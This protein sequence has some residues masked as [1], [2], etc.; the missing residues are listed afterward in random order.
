[1]D[2]LWETC[3]ESLILR[4]V[5]PR[6]TLASE[7][8]R[9]ETVEGNGDKKMNLVRNELLR[10]F[11]RAMGGGKAALPLEPD[12]PLYV[13]RFGADPAKDPILA[14]SERIDWA[15]S[16]SV[17]VLTG[18][19]GNGKSTELRR[20]K[21][22]LEDR[23]CTVILIDMLEYVIVT[24][25][26]ELSDFILSLVTGFAEVTKQEEGLDELHETYWA[27][28]KNF[29]I[30]T[31]VDAKDSIIKFGNDLTS[32]EL[33]LRLKTDPTFKQTLQKRLRGHLTNL[34][35]EARDYAVA[36][37]DAL[38][39]KEQFP[40]L[41]VVLLVDS[42]EQIRGVGEDAEKVHRSVVETFSGQ[43][44]LDFPQL[45]VVYTAPPYLMSLAPTVA[46]SLGGNPISIWPNIQIRKKDGKEDL[47]NIA[48]MRTIVE[49]RFRRWREF[50]EENHL[51]H[52]AINSGGDIRDFF[53]LIRECLIALGTTR[54]EKTTDDILKQVAQQLKNDM[55]PIADA[56]ARCLFRIHNTKETRLEDTNELPRLARFFDHNLI[57]NYQNGGEPWYDVHPVVVDEI[58]LHGSPIPLKRP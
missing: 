9:R 37:V 53:R 52:M 13:P 20:L 41:K 27:R 11:Y 7:K 15:E 58:K 16:E 21:K 45:H 1:L 29:L 38:R 19:R 36:V 35:R 8:L 6:R 50:I 5:E 22:L 48:I 57:M 56:D 42:L 47:S 18:F 40:D 30:K 23:G 12:S 14:L 34:V 46:R 25:P 4:D 32:A 49:R 26:L 10:D 54:R 31:N 24:K 33:G 55:L 2:S 39:K 51:N 17:N 3:F 43:K 28:F 44:S